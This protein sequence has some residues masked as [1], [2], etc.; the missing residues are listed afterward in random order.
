MVARA[1]LRAIHVVL[2]LTIDLTVIDLSLAAIC[3]KDTNTI[4]SVNRNDISTS[5][6]SRG[7]AEHNCSLSHLVCCES[8]D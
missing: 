3:T 7:T 5:V 6:D 1:A 4:P 8:I 2:Q